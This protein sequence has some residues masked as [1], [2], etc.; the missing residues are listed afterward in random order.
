MIGL[1]ELLFKLQMIYLAWKPEANL[2]LVCSVDDDPGLNVPA[3]MTV[4]LST[5]GKKYR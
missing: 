3:S 4:L 5:E 2:L 1:H